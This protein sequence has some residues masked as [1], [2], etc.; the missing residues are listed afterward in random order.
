MVNSGTRV[1][2]ETA[3]SELL[4]GPPR[5]PNQIF[6]HVTSFIMRADDHPGTSRDLEEQDGEQD[7]DQDEQEQDDQDQ[8]DEDGGAVEEDNKQESSAASSSGPPKSPLLVPNEKDKSESKP[9]DKG[10]TSNAAPVN[11]DMIMEALE[12]LHPKNLRGTSLEQIVDFLLRTYPVSRDR[13]ALQGE[14]LECLQTAV[15]QGLVRLTQNGS[16]RLASFREQASDREHGTE[17]PTPARPDKGSA[18][19]RRGQRG[20]RATK[21][22]AAK[23]PAR[24]S[25]SRSRRRPTAGSPVLSEDSEDSDCCGPL[26]P[27]PSPDR[28]RGRGRTPVTPTRPSRRAPRAPT[29]GPARARR[30]QQSRGRKASTGSKR[31][32]KRPA[33]RAPRTRASPRAATRASSRASKRTP[34]MQPPAKRRRR[35][36]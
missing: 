19:G 33:S 4:F 6:Q 31:A 17:A 29:P 7:Q 34:S 8:E 20:P 23:P 25:A 16:Y 13:E 2:R 26:S 32:A 21:K 22:S 12:A 14:L 1:P 11:S 36:L 35:Q 30:S 5:A 28:S 24:P 9:M 10:S 15:D 18:K 27:A 3:L